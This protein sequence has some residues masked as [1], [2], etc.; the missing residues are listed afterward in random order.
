MAMTVAPI[1]IMVPG[2]NA[3]KMIVSLNRGQMLEALQASATFWFVVVA[4]AV[5]WRQRCFSLLDNTLKGALRDASTRPQLLRRWSGRLTKWEYGLA[6]CIR[7]RGWGKPAVIRML[8]LLEEEPRRSL[9]LLG[10]STFAEL[11]RSDLHPTR[12]TTS[13]GVLSAFTL[14]NI[15]DDR[16]WG[17]RLVSGYRRLSG[18]THRLVGP[19]S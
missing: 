12:P 10:V 15:E 6:A 5:G 3:F 11:D 17:P 7:T 1:V 18:S 13:P 14:L 19:L 2:I 16:C 4:L 8:E 9:A